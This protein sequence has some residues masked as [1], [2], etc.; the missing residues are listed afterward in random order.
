MEKRAAKAQ[1]CVDNLLDPIARL[2][3]DKA[4]D[5]FIQKNVN[6]RPYSTQLIENYLR[7]K[8]IMGMVLRKFRK[9]IRFPDLN[10]IEHAW[11]TL[12]IWIA[13]FNPFRE[14]SSSCFDKGIGFISAVELINKIIFRMEFR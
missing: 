5:S 14:R 4:N 3:A 2:C 1:S 7:D 9:Q 10:A 13:A 12:G 11:D 8:T 6:S